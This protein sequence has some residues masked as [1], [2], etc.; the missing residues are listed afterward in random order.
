MNSEQNAQPLDESG[1]AA[2]PIVSRRTYS[3]D[4]AVALMKQ[5]KKLTHRYFSDDE[6]I[7]MVG[8]II[9][10]ELG[11]ECW[12]SEFWRDRQGAAWESDWSLYGG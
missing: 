4:E 2:K 5:G 8:N 11:Q 1:N 3:K 10:M 6:W 9:R 12:A 7:T